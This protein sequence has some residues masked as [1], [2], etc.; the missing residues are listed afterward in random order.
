MIWLMLYML[1]DL[2]LPTFIQLSM[3]LKVFPP[4]ASSVSPPVTSPTKS[5][6][7]VSAPSVLPTRFSTDSPVITPSAAPVVGGALSTDG[8]CCKRLCWTL[9]E[10]FVQLADVVLD[11]DDA[12]AVLD[13]KLV[14]VSV[15]ARL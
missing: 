11:T 4:V 12:T 14:T 15:L 9:L 3:K 2:L 6:T 1:P 13:V 7:A 5:P 10:L 8:K